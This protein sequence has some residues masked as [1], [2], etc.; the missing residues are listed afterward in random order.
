M[1]DRGAILPAGH[2]ANAAY[3]FDGASGNWISSSFY[4]NAL[5][6]WVND[7]NSK[8]LPAAY[9]KNGWTTLL[10]ADQYTESTADTAFYE[11]AYKGESSTAFPHHFTVPMKDGFEI[12]KATPFGNT[13][14]KDFAIETIRQE[15][16]G[17]GSVTDFL[18]VSFSSTDYVGHQ[19]GPNSV[20]CEDTY[21][22]LDKD[23][24]DLLSFLDTW[25]GKQNVLVFLTADHGVAPAPGFLTKQ[26]IPAGVI[27]EKKLI[28]TINKVVQQELGDSNL[29]LSIQNMQVYVN[30]EKM[31]EK[32]V[33]IE[34]LFSIIQSI[35]ME[36]EGIRNVFLSDSPEHALLPS[37]LVNMFRNSFYPKRCGEIV[38][39]YEPFWIEGHT[40]GTTHGSV[41][42]YDTHVPLIWYGWDIKQGSGSSETSVTDIA[43]TIA[44]FLNILE[45][46]GCIG[47]PIQGLR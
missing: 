12:L 44:D 47:R 2:T 42:S 11:E 13:V 17:K 38:L 24:A 32:G 39:V 23:I 45:P 37:E 46:S 4:M 36:T 20:E 29:V 22:R 21:L 33:T 3:W 5:P 27:N 8:K 34:K 16:M 28:S 31:K 40:K 25:I 19:F 6:K 18:T 9:L 10:P 26:K 1:K 30:R 43:P 7:F 15:Q 14:T 35:G 41:F